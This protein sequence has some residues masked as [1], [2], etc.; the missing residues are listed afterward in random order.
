MPLDPGLP[1]KRSSYIEKKA[2]MAAVL[3][4]SLED[5]KERR[6]VCP[7]C[8]IGSGAGF[9]RQTASTKKAQSKPEDNAYIMFTSGSTGKPKGVQISHENVMNFL[10]SMKE[11]LNF[12][13]EQSILSVTTY[14]FDISVLELFL[15]LVCG[16]KIILSSGQ[17]CADQ[18]RLKKFIHQ[19]QPDYVQATPALWQTLL[20]E[21]FED[22]EQITA[23]CGGDA[24]NMALAKSLKQKCLRVFNMY[25]PTETTVW[26]LMHQLAGDTPEVYIGKPIGN[27][28]VY[29]LDAYGN[30][31][32][33]G[34][35]GRLYIGGAGVSK[36]YLDNEEE[37]KKRFIDN[38]FGEGTKFS[39]VRGGGYNSQFEN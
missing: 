4:D 1:L 22:G 28:T 2:G 7:C 29:L 3:T 38:P 11:K 21:G 9:W 31:L 13:E 30:L 14:A 17:I 16:G 37:T 24:M 25:G 34:V 39:D 8:F 6:E 26:S 5:E 15:P 19:Y 12:Q 33:P 18:V 20:S 10:W 32:P 35:K 27:T 36:G 23:L